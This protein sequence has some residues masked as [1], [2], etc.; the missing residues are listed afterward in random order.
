MEMRR[1]G[2]AALAVLLAAAGPPT[3]DMPTDSLADGCGFAY[4]L[5]E[6]SDG[7]SGLRLASVIIIVLP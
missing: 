6:F 2:L 3:A 7:G 4:G 5:P 1:A